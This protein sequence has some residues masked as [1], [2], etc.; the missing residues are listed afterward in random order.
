MIR[1][2]LP[3]SLIDN[4]MLD[5]WLRFEQGG[6]IHLGT[7]K[8]ELGQ[9]VLTALRQ[10][11]AE[12]LEVEPDRIRVVSGE[13]GLSPE[14]G[15]TAGS[16]S[17]EASGGAIRLVCA[18]VRALAA[19]AAAAQ[20]GCR[21]AELSVRDG[22]FLQA[23]ASTGTTYW[24]LAD[25]LDLHRHATGA[26]PPRRPD[27]FRLIGQSL[28][29]TDLP[30]K[31]CGP[32]FIHDLRPDGLLHARVLRTPGRG[33]SIV[34]VDE[35]RIRRAAGP[36]ITIVRLHDFLAFAAEDEAA[37]DRALE[38]AAGAVTWSGGNAGQPLHA[39]P[40]YLLTLPTIDRVVTAPARAG[41]AGT[42]RAV[43]ATYTRPYIAHGSIGPSCALG[44]WDGARLTVW[45]HSQGVGPLRHSIARALRLD[46]GTVT[47]LH[48]PG[49]G[50]YGHNGADDAALDAA[51]VA[52]SMPGRPVRVRWTREDELSA[53]PVGG[54]S[55][56][57]LRAE[58]DADG[59]PAS[60][61]VQIWS[62]PHGQRP[63]ANGGINLLAELALADHEQS[64]GSDDVP[65]AAGG[66]GN[67]NSLALYDLPE[68]R[69]L[70]HLVADPPLRTSSLRGL[71]AQANVFAIE[72]FM[73]ELA[74][75]AGCDPVQYRLGLLSDPRARRVVEEVAAMSG[76]H[77]RG[78]AGGGS[79]LGIAFSRY[80]NRAAY[81]AAVAEVE[82]GEEV[83]VR[84]LWCAVDAGLVINPDGAAN[85]VEGGAVQATSWTL[86]EEVRV[87]TPGIVSRTWDTYPILRFSEVPE[88]QTRFVGSQDDPPL[89]LGEVALGPVTAAIGN[90]L[91]HAL[92][93][94]IR[95]L[96]FS[97]ERLLASLLPNAAET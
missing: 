37:A 22:E 85:Q 14:E 42:G 26:A 1:N 35:A 43:E 92:G 96:P 66:G 80:K 24:T 75:A 84:R 70:H 88:V 64:G 91:A 74:E 30:A 90:A 72:S 16:Q 15:M 71:G 33:A 7:G 69:V 27:E 17:I 62:P 11:A 60:W 47:V 94:R 59:R 46:P 44:L 23:G 63:G 86:K 9:G 57:S 6:A 8:V 76:W 87:D 55:V 36:P 81:L 97:R 61:D 58:L 40:R 79:G 21:V 53:G 48:R 32:G 13:T 28:P 2:D 65:D 78:A 83:L 52:R 45:S 93:T 38:A 18:E 5:R 4:P 50:C 20:L 41:S 39:D 51:L 95:D 56:V 77:D 89:G 54:A 68:Q 49:A 3:R 25:R 29:R 67:R 34:S 31:L 82:L 12:E 19:A 10:M 73:D